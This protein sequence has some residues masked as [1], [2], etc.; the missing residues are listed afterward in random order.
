MKTTIKDNKTL[1]EI[2]VE[3]NHRFP[4]LRLEFVSKKLKPGTDFRDKKNSNSALANFRKTQKEGE[5]AFDENMTVTDLESQF[6]DRYGLNAQVF[7]RSGKLW[8]ETTATDKWTLG[9]QNEQGQELF[10]SDLNNEREENDYHEQ[11]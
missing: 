10:N 4:F 11:E 5:I 8:L 2:Q 1:R 9:Y 7:R 3:F 6:L